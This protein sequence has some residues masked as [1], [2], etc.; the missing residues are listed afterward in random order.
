MTTDLHWWSA[1]D[2]AAA[3][4][5]R[6]V[7]AAEALEH[8]IARI[9]RLDGPVNAIV[10]WD[11]ERA[12]EAARSADAAVAA[13][14]DVG[15]LHGVP[16]TIKDSFQTVG[17]VTTSGAPEL[18]DF[19]PTEDAAPV[20]RLRAAG[21]IPFAK[22]NL[23]IYAGDIQSF[24]EVYGTTNNP[25]DLARTPGGSSGGSAAALAM[26]FTSL[27]LG[28]DIGGSIRVPAHY[29][30]VSG[31]K[32]S[33][34]IV[35]AHGQ[36]PG[37][38]GTLSQADLAVAGPMSRSVRDL[39]LALDVLVGPDRWNAPAWRIELPPP[40]GEALDQLRIGAWLDDDHC[41]VDA[42]TRTVLE[43]LV[44]QIEAAGGRVDT[45][46]R[47]GFTLEKIDGVFRDLLMAAL[48]G[49]TPPG[50]LDR[51]AATAGDSAAERAAR[52]TAMRHREW[53]A[54]NERRLQIR[55][56]WREFFE[57]F[58][59]ILMPVQPR[60]AIPHDH[61]M[62]QWDRTV[63]IDGV[64]RPY[65]DLFGW[66]GPAGAGMLPATVVPAGLGSDGLP[67]GVQIVGPYLHDRTTLRA[68]ALIAKLAG[69]CP[70]PAL[71]LA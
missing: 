40:R 32:P 16:I 57:R 61:S 60:G 68:A 67:I 65:L 53:L 43:H 18:A 66:T 56:R 23:P 46:A 17:C 30:G 63:D 28:S 55:E 20:A 41:P 25:H 64:D 37:M 31:H 15:P 7:S 19:V 8:Q 45:E 13:G 58:D 62:P 1:T 29:S 27:E 11:V 5:G 39:E 44:G 22:S 71:A 38:P 14:H 9:E 3:I 49:G 70:K 26:G 59:I 34:G 35:A 12:R 50:E 54:H 52:S 48:A 10:H 42:S 33:Y 24:N 2:L 69:G 36:I 47:P 6:E 4:R 21:A 51:L